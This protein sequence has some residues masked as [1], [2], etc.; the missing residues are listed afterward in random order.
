MA[1]GLRF[2]QE[3]V[4]AFNARR[5]GNPAMHHTDADPG[6]ESS[7]QERIEKWCRENGFPFFHDRS[8]GWNEPGFPDLVIALRC[9]K[10]LWIELKSKDGRLKSEQEKWRL[11]LMALGHEHFVIRSF[12]RFLEVANELRQN[13]VSRSD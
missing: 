3:Q 5:K 6:P 2:T 10:T 8:R 13:P 11:Q 7:L 4:D 1:G 12:K 9:G